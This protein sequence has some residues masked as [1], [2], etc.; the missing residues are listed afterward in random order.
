MNKYRPVSI[1]HAIF[2]RFMNLS[3]ENQTKDLKTDGEKS[4]NFFPFENIVT[5]H[6][7]YFLLLSS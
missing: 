7:L 4:F 3:V 2:T 6:R 1:Y 5:I